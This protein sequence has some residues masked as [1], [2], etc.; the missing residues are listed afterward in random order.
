MSQ[1]SSGESEAIDLDEVRA[2]AQKLLSYCES[3]DW[4]GYDPYDA[5]NSRIYQALPFLRFRLP[6]F[7]LTQVL[8]RCP[9]N[10]RPLLLV[11]Q[12]QN[13]K[14]LGLFTS[15]LIKLRKLGLVHTDRSLN[16]LLLR[17]S[18]LRSPGSAHCCW[19]YNFPW[20]SRAAFFPRWVPNVICTTFAGNAVLD[21]FEYFADERYLEMA[22][23][24]SD[25][26]VQELYHE[27]SDDVACINYMPLAT[28]K[29]HNANLLGAAFLCRTARL[30]GE[31]KW[32][33]PAVRA[34]RYS[35]ASQ[36]ADGS[37]P[38]GESENP[39]QR[40]ID[41]FHTG[42]NLCA[43]RT[44]EANLGTREFEG[45]IR[46][47]YRFFKN[48]FFTPDGAA[49]YFHDRTWPVDIH[50]VAQSIITLLTFEEL[51]PEGQTL[52]GSVYRWA[53]EHLYSREGWFYFQKH[54]RYTNRIP[55]MRW[56]QAWMLLAMSLVLESKD[57]S[58]RPEMPAVRQPLAAASS[59]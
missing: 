25:F 35:V 51:D 37:W 11:P 44:I 30:S 57:D 56:S 10:L 21:A 43:L 8:K 38:Y 28:S 49:K 54:R 23:S 13:P 7:A 53:I 58:R 20:Q 2:I 19:G 15:A 16:H 3:R 40:W 31:T 47:G 50:S 36:N 41:N 48:N 42:F 32:I 46:L 6:G 22:R 33:E 24:A 12:S 4:A 34:T 29:V 1:Q 14:G 59:N 55:Y 17:L 5:L 39:P 27:E 18:E 9:I 52:A 26:I 45:P